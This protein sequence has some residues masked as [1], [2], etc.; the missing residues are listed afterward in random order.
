MLSNPSIPYQSPCAVDLARRLAD[1]RRIIEVVAGPRQVGK[2]T[3]LQQLADDIG[4][5]VRYA[6]VDAPPCAVPSG[7][8]RMSA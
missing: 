2:K 8:L 3:L 5:G 6:G 7:L 4:R 1:P